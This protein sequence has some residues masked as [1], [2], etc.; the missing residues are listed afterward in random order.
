MVVDEPEQRKPN[1]EIQDQPGANV[2]E[3][4]SFFTDAAADAKKLG[5]YSQHFISF[6]AYEWVH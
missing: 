2:D 3:L 4:F 1:E 6:E 5:P